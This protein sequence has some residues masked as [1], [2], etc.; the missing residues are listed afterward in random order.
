MKRSK[1]MKRS[2][3]KV[4]T[5]GWPPG[6]LQDDSRELSQWLASKPDAPMLVRQACEA[7]HKKPRGSYGANEVNAPQPKREPV[8]NEAYR[9]W[10]ATLPCIRCGVIGYSQA[11][12]PNQGR[13][14]GQK[15]DDTDCFPLCCTRPGILGC[16]AEF[17]QLRYITLS[18]RRALE[19]EYIAV[20]KAMHE[21]R[22]LPT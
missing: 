5:T 21:G 2:G 8:R 14:L 15:A 22:I 4:K 16:H 6:M 13:G 12:H 10:V 20:T 19:L 7:I 17:D 11:A 1:P 18:E 9:R 3:F